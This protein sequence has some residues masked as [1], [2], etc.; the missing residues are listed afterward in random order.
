M[1][2]AQIGGF[3]EARIFLSIGGRDGAVAIQE[4]TVLVFVDARSVNFRRS[5]AAR[6]TRFRTD[7]SKLEAA[8]AIGA[9][10]LKPGAHARLAECALEA[11][12]HGVARVGREHLSAAFTGGSQGKHYRTLLLCIF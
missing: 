6:K 11:A 4:R 5:R 1:S 7:R 12:D 9:N 2:S 8:A 10:V 3:P